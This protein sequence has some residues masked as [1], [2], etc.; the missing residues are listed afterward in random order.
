MDEGDLNSQLRSESIVREGIAHQAGS[1]SLVTLK[2][3][4]KSIND[5]ILKWQNP[6][7]TG[8]NIIYKLGE[9]YKKIEREKKEGV[10]R[11][12][13][14]RG[15]DNHHQS[16]HSKKISPEAMALCMNL[17]QLIKGHND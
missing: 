13:H 3:Y 6:T 5:P 11:K 10:F 17:H 4:H 15:N 7:V 8:R 14:R 16:H 12:E 9:M 1:D 2:L